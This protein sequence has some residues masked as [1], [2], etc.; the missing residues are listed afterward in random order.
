MAFEDRKNLFEM[1]NCWECRDGVMFLVDGQVDIG[2]KIEV[3][4]GLMQSTNS[5]SNTV[6]QLR[7]ALT[8]AI[9]T[10][11]RLRLVVE[12][13]PQDS[14]ILEQQ[15][16]QITTINPL[17]T[18]MLAKRQEIYRQLIEKEYAIVTS[19]YVILTFG[20]QRQRLSKNPIMSFFQ[21]LQTRQKDPLASHATGHVTYTKSEFAEIMQ[22]AKE[23][24]E[25]LKA[26]LSAVY[27]CENMNTDDMFGLMYRMLN[28]DH[29]GKV[30]P[31]YK[32]TWQNYSRSAALEHKSLRPP[33][34]RMQVAKHNV[35]NGRLNTGKIGNYYFG[36][37]SLAATPD[38][39]VATMVD[40]LLDTEGR[41]IYVLDIEHEAYQDTLTRLNSTARQF[42]ATVQSSE[43]YVDRSQHVGLHQNNAAIEHMT[44]TGD[45]AFRVGCN[46]V[47]YDKDQRVL[48]ERIDAALGRA[49][50]VPG[51][52]FRRLQEGILNPFLQTLPH[53]GL[54][55]DATTLMVGYNATHFF[56]FN[57]QYKGSPTA[58]SLYQTPEGNIVGHD[59]FDPRTKASN[60]VV[61]GGTGGGKTFFVQMSV[62]DALAQENT[63]IV[64][65][66][67]GK[68]YLNFVQ[69]FGGAFIDIKAGGT[70]SINPFDLP[71]GEHEP[72]EDKIAYLLTQLRA[73]LPT[74]DVEQV[75]IED[76]ILTSALI[77]LYKRKTKEYGDGN[78]GFIKQ[79]Q[80]A[81]LSDFVKV[82]NN[83]EQVGSVS[84]K[85]E[86]IELAS[87]MALRLQKW[88]GDTPYGRFIDKPTNVPTHNNRL[89]YYETSQLG[90][91]ELAQVGIIAIANLVYNLV[92]RDYSRQKIIIF[93]E[94]WKLFDIPSAAGFIED[95]YR[96][97]RRYNA[98]V[99]SVT[100]GVEEFQSGNVSGV[101]NNTQIFY[102]LPVGDTNAQPAIDL[103]AMTE[104]AANTYKML[105]QVDGKYSECLMIRE[106]R[107]GKKEAGK[108]WIRPSK[109]DFSLFSTAAANIDMRQ[110]Y[111]K[112]YGSVEEA[113]M[114]MA[115]PEQYTDLPEKAN[116]KLDP[117]LGG[118][119]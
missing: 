52:P 13:L 12:S 49:V 7:S 55:I 18:T 34:L 111:I 103:L 41:C 113:V 105:K 90:D 57:G 23:Y 42:S 29:T 116:N 4:P 95:L 75:S 54:A 89:V 96:R 93:D 118:R 6:N 39:T 99:W 84:A 71:E 80:G 59:Y 43:G 31:S 117:A 87:A 48:T 88:T 86:Q 107:S 101:L 27:S 100:Q 104:Q 83:I 33:T 70:T 102:L 79:F 73:M 82:L 78:G 24:R 98:A 66:D 65:I 92:D 77:D 60:A 68:S 74:N 53:N 26:F 109:F 10:K 47:F 112:R 5:I 15:Q 22:R 28:P 38:E 11:A 46:I 30:K 69:A 25:K 45:H 20:E 119:L 40:Q 67:R 61:V 81:I 115:Y 108:F 9:P 85:Q 97:L 14:T 63:D 72:N 3:P 2:L 114:R 17:I 1:L 94:C 76:A 44:M 58:R 62:S 19:A 110:K 16:T 51:S 56:P 8:N 36:I 64:L 32:P 21:Q 106:L 37:L 50:S 91:G 35:E